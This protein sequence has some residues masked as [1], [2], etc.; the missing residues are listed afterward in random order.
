MEQEL[1]KEQIAEQK[2]AEKAK[3]IAEREAMRLAQAEAKAKEKAEKAA[4]REAEKAE[5]KAQREA[6]KAEREAERQA[7]KEAAKAKREQEAQQRRERLEARKAMTRANGGRRPRAV[8]FEFTGNGLSSPQEFSL[9]GKVFNYIK[10]NFE[11]GERVE[12]ESLQ[13][14]LSEMLYGSSVRS[15]LSKLEEMGHLTFFFDEPTSNDE[16]AESDDQ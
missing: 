16:P 15:F 2:A 10:E 6:E 5:R 12:I 7:A 11:I 9:R 3:K 1:T 14:Q 4:Q 8:A 13:E